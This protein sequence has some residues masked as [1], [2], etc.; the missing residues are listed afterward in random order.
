MECIQNIHT[1]TLTHR[2]HYF[3]LDFCYLANLILI[4]YLTF[5]PSSPHLF[6]MNFVNC[7]G[8]L[9]FSVIMWRNSL[10]FHSIEKVTS[11]FIHIYPNLVVFVL[12]WMV[13]HKDGIVKFPSTGQEYHICIRNDEECTISFRDVFY[14]HIVLFC[15]WQIGYFIKTNGMLL[16]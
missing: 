4:V 10:V 6:M 14:T 7:T 5:Y 9:L 13:K 1:L 15:F 16:D 3:M 11:V 2:Y 8:P 12:R